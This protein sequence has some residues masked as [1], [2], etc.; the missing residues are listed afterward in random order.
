MI[1]LLPCIIGTIQEEACSAIPIRHVWLPIPYLY[2]CVGGREHE[3]RAMPPKAANDYPTETEY[4]AVCG[5][6]QAVKSIRMSANCDL[7]L[8]HVVADKAGIQKCN[9]FVLADFFEACSHSFFSNSLE[10]FV[11]TFPN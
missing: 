6:M 5:S 3:I 2:V 4:P 8:F 11:W 10:P 9:Y 7:R 1:V